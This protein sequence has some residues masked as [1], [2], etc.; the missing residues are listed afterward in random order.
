MDN[1]ISFEE[2]KVGLRPFRG[3]I[4]GV[5]TRGAFMSGIGNAY[6][7]KILFAASISSFRKTKALSDEELERLRGNARQVVAEAV[8]VLRERMGDETHHKSGTF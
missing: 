6:S 5:L 8:T 1:E 7:D 2:F 3:E 4:K